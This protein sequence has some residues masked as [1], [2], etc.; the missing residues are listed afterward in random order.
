MLAQRKS[1][2]VSQA[3]RRFVSHSRGDIEEGDGE[4]LH[5]DGSL[6]TS[7][8]IGLEIL[9]MEKLKTQK[10]FSTLRLFMS[11]MVCPSGSGEVIT[12]VLFR[13]FTTSTNVMGFRTSTTGLKHFS[14]LL[15]EGK[16]FRRCWLLWAQH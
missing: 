6:D 7:Q 13:V 5:E 12:F 14:K 15:L 8:T 16:S 1:A 11:L 9:K 4:A 10:N 3:R 2:L